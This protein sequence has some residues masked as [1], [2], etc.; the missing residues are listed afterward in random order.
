MLTTIKNYPEKRT[1]YLPFY[2]FYALWYLG[3]LFVGLCRCLEECWCVVARFLARPVVVL[4]S[5]HHILD[6]S[7]SVWLADLI[8]N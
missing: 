5:N 8:I 3:Q 4:V 1:F 7:R 2:T 6:Y